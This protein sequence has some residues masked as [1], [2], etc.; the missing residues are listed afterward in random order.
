MAFAFAKKFS[1]M[2]P[3]KSLKYMLHHHLGGPQPGRPMK[4]VHASSLTKAEGFCPRYVALHDATGKKPKDEYLTAADVV[5]YA[6]GNDLQHAIIHHFADMGKAISHWKCLACDKLHE[7]CRRPPKCKNCGCRGFKPEEVRVV[8]AVSGASCGIDMLVEEGGSKLLPVE[9]KTMQ[10]D[11]FKGLLAP[12]AEHRHRTNLYLRIIGESTE[13]HASLINSQKAKVLYVCK[14][15][16]IS[17]PEL[18]KWGLS[19][20]FTPFKEYELTRKDADT[21]TISNLA[22]VVKDYREKKVGMPCGICPTALVKRALICSMKNVC[23]SGDHPV[24]Y[25]WKNK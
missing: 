17:D 1:D 6:M 23:F 14:G 21:Q 11:Q 19:D 20:Q 2:V 12:L 5:T 15:G 8:S 24:E 9:L 22:K 3:K 10:K 13:P 16:Y 7:F 4:N 18:K 25:D